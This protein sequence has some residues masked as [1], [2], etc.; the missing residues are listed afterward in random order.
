[1]P[2]RGL[3]LFNKKEW[4][5]FREDLVPVLTDDGRT[6]VKMF[7][8][9]AAAVAKIRPGATRNIPKRIKATMAAFYDNKPA[10]TATFYDIRKGL[11]V[12]AK[13][14][15]PQLSNNAEKRQ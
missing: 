11:M 3:L 7:T 5:K 12:S 9:P 4:A 14:A 8:N 10:K 13:K 2:W 1:V 6:D 15:P